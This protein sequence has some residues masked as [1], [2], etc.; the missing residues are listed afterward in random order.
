MQMC[1]QNK[2]EKTRGQKYFSHKITLYLL[3]QY[4]TC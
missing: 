3:L 1:V 2:T 4:K